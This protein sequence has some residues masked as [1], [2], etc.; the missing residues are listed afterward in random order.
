MISPSAAVRFP[1]TPLGRSTTA[2]GAAIVS[3]SLQGVDDELAAQ[4]VA[5]AKWRKAYVSFFARSTWASADSKAAVDIAERGLRS[6]WDRMMVTTGQA[7]LPLGEWAADQHEAAPNGLTARVIHGEAPPL[8][9]LVVPYRGRMLRGAELD[10]QLDDWTLRGIVEPGFARAVRLVAE[11]PEWLAMP[12]HKVILLGAGAAMGPLAQLAAHGADV[13][14]I[15][16][17]VPA[18]QDRIG[19]IAMSGAG[20]VT[21][22]LDQD[23]GV[24]GLDVA[25]DLARARSWL[26]TTWSDTAAPVLS[27]NTYADGG[28][29]VLVN[30][31]GDVLAR[32]LTQVRPDAVLAYL[33]TPTD[34][35]LVPADAVRQAR[36]RARSVPVERSRAPIDPNRICRQSASSEVRADR[37]GRLRKR[38]GEVGHDRRRPGSQLRFGQASAALA[39]RATS[40][41]RWARVDLRRPGLVDAFGH[42]EQ[43]LGLHLCRRRGIRR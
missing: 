32:D 25:S 17:P 42:Q 33:N 38:V 41:C 18:V 12:G 40:P 37:R 36:E 28:D 35:F 20:T 30:L 3:D 6:L 34:S 13:V 8:E 10:R 27:T 7:E 19:Q 43:G 24:E 16:V 39:R 11:R 26:S 2:T 5:S 14:A 1:R 9:E 4:A 15:D 22:P 29:H 23:N 21:V 31:A